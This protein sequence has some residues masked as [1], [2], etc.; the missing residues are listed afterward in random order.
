[1]TASTVSV[2]ASSANAPHKREQLQALH[3]S[4]RRSGFDS[5]I[6]V[7]A[8]YRPSDIAVLWGLPKSHDPDRSRREIRVRNLVFE[9]HKGPIVV[10]EAPL[11]GRWVSR[12][13]KRT[14]L[15]KALF[16]ASA[17][18]TRWLLPK[19]R[20][21]DQVHTWF[22]VGIGGGFP[23]DGGFRLYDV[24]SERWPRLK[25]RLGLSDPKPWR[26]DGEHILVIG[27]VPGDASLRGTNITQWLLETCRTCVEICDRP[28]WVRPHPLMHEPDLLCLKD[29]LRAIRNVRIDEGPGS[30]AASL[31]NAWAT[32]TYSSGAGV[33]SLF[34][35]VPVISVSPASPVYG[36]SDHAITDIVAPNLYDRSAWLNMIAA[37]QWSASELHDGS[38]W[39]AI[40]DFLALPL[41]RDAAQCIP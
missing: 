6:V 34:E 37:C 24:R 40:A 7:S 3:A 23:D 9:Q 4:A 18:H 5:Q 29:Q 30:L 15:M 12:K 8:E 1:V 20:Y 31:A 35:G 2:Y 26:T 36:V 11:L 41:G 21:L 22:R 10:I 25:E 19:D 27:Q 17:P 16:P 28:V 38:V 39:D 32:V 14:P 13:R 33:E